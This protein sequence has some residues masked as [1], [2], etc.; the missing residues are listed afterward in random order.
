MGGQGPLTTPLT[1]LLNIK[2]PIL[3][4]GM[5]RTSGGPLAAAVSNA[6]GLGCIGG[7]GYTPTQLREIIHELKSHLKSPDLSF[8]VD[9]ARVRGRRT[10]ITHMDN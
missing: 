2:H 10:M 3:L 6:G 1:T 7:L 8:G 9:L 4:A 5:A